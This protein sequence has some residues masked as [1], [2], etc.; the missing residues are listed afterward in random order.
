VLEGW[1]DRTIEDW[2]IFLS[3]VQRRAVDRAVGGPSRDRRAGDRQVRRRAAS[4]GRV[5]ARARGRPAHPPHLVR[6]DGSEVLSGLFERLA[7]DL[8]NHAAFA[9]VHSLAMRALGHDRPNVDRD[10]ARRR[11]SRAASGGSLPAAARGARLSDDWRE[12][13]TRVIEAGG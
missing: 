10:A 9:S 13:I 3:P 8:A 11:F 4:G 1:R 2:M 7:P 6:A 12:E 5:R